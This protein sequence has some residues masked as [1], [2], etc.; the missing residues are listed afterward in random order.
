[1]SNPDSLHCTRIEFIATGKAGYRSA[2]HGSPDQRIPRRVARGLREAGV[3]F[4][5]P[6]SCRIRYMVL[7]EHLTCPNCGYDLYAIPEVRCP[8]CGF[9]YDAGALRSIVASE[10]WIRFT[11]ARCI[12]VRTA[13][14]AALAFPAACERIGVSGWAQFWLVA[15]AY[16]ATFLTWVVVSD[17]YG[18]LVSVPNLLRLFVVLV[19]SLRF[20]LGFL[21]LL[22]LVGS[23][24]ALA[25]AWV[26]RIRDWPALSPP[27]TVR[28]PIWRRP[29]ERYSLAATSIL[30]LATTLV[31]IASIP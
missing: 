19:F 25:L 28:S 12:I 4:D 9:R 26:V 22:S 29:I 24:V 20:I 16:V 31:L 1:M 13:L 3:Q 7:A 6:R 10:D 14:A 30:I 5:Q 17:S 27:E 15:V 8:E 18:G 23:I 21:P 11:A 2:L